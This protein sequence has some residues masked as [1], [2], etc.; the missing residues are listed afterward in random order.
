MY[1]HPNS[2]TPTESKMNGRDLYMNRLFE[3]RHE[4]VVL[5]YS[6]IYGFTFIKSTTTTLFGNG[7]NRAFSLTNTVIFE[8]SHIRGN[9]VSKH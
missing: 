2:V 5:S 8:L 6:H 4:L 7:I 1:V 9:K 3:K